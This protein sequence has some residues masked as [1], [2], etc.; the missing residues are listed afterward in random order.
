MEART[1]RADR[2]GRPMRD[3]R[4]SVTDRCNFRCQY[5]MPAEVFG[6]DYPFLPRSE[7]LT[8]EEIVRLVRLFAGFGVK[9]VRLT[10]GEPLLRKDLPALIRMV[11]R[12]PGVDDIALTTNASLLAGSVE[13][14]V[15]AGLNRV[16]VSL[17]AL[18]SD[19]FARMSGGR[20]KVKSVLAGIDAA[21]A[22]G[23]PVKVNM[24]V[25]KGVNDGEILPMARHFKEKGIPLRFIEFMDVGNTNGWKLDQVVSKQ[26]ILEKI[27]SEMPL[28]PL[29]PAYHGEVADRYRYR[30]NGIEVGVISSV[31]APF[32][33]SC[34]RA[35]LSAEGK[36]YTCLFASRGTDFRTPLRDGVG[37]DEL[38]RL[39]DRVWSRR[40]DRYSEER[41]SGTAGGRDKVEM[42]YIGG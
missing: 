32:C 25:Q 33:G 2:L 38:I 8:F 34:T 42:S 30:D 7:L 41:S 17:D 36:L 37:D 29:E 19:V 10:G 13:E 24:V 21:A 18:D 26:E 4:I 6:P 15:D 14:L 28:E 16:N 27:G 40:S 31:T 3:L 35:R 23:L 12:V 11:S 20:G 5:C 39:I 22:A 9:K 1:K